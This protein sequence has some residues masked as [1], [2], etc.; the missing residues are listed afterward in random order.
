M[1]S[2]ELYA[3]AVVVGPY[4]FGAYIFYKHARGVTLMPGRYGWVIGCLITYC[5]LG[6]IGT[7]VFASPVWTV[8]DVIA[9]ALFS[10]EQGYLVSEKVPRFFRH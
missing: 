2:P 7:H 6:P 5:L 10:A 8:Y 4:S 9:L 3:L 1:L